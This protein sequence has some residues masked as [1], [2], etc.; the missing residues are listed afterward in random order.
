MKTAIRLDRRIVAIVIAGLALC[1]TVWFG[2]ERR[3]AQSAATANEARIA[4]EERTNQLKERVLRLKQ[5][6]VVDSASL[7]TRVAALEDALPQGVDDLRVAGRLESTA[8]DAGV[9][10]EAL[11]RVAADL[12]DPKVSGAK[13]VTYSVRVSGSPESVTSWMEARAGDAAMVLSIERVRLTSRAA[14]GA[15]VVGFGEG[16]L[17]AEMTVRIWYSGVPRVTPASGASTTP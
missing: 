6:G 4:A 8:A 12:V 17:V 3:Q 9:A 2:F 10:V 15:Q 13:F 7:T 16:V 1:L 5:A 11:K 14:G